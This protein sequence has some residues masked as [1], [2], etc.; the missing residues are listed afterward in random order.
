MSFVKNGVIPLS[1]PILYEKIGLE[2]GLE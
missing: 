1:S 2:R